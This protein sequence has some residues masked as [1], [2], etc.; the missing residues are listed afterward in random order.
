MPAV[1]R[2]WIIARRQGAMIAGLDFA[3]REASAPEP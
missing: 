3:Y 1:N 2:G